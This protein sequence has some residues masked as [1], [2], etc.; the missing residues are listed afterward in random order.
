MYELAPLITDLAIILGI[1]GV[2]ALIC[3]RIN[4]PVILGYLL[5]GLLLGPHTPPYPFVEDM[6]NI[7]TLSELGVIF[8]MFSLGLEF[9][10]HKLKRVGFTATITAFLEVAG[11]VILG[12]I[13]GLILG[14]SFL[15]SLFL[16]GALSISSTTIIIKALDELKLK[17]REFAQVIFGILVVEDLIAIIVLVS[18][19]LTVITESFFSTELAFSIFRLVVVVGTWFL[20]G[21]FLIPSFF[22]RYSKYMN[23][24]TL[25]LISVGLCLFLVCIASYFHYSVA[26]GAFI[27]GSILAETSL[28]H[29]IE[30]LIAPIKDIF[31]AVFFVS[32]G[33]L[34]DP[35]VIFDQWKLVLLLCFLTILGKFLF[36]ALGA[37]LSGQSVATSTRVGLGMAQIGEFSFIIIGT[38]LTLNAISPEIYPIIVA[39]SVVTT[40]ATP[41]FLKFSD[42]ISSAMIHNIPSPLKHFINGYTKSVQRILNNPR[43]KPLYSKTALRLLITGIIAAAIFLMI[44]YIMRGA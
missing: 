6:P 37:F 35:L 9:S 5:A 27:M 36:T 40:F 34:I 18:L 14:W 21:Y 3:R 15:D 42:N 20:L 41:Y 23:N 29:R 31:A 10:F 26:L 30:P 22:K 17:G 43:Y 4:Q 39:V 32:V 12:I 19:T 44:E 8:L 11:M 38:G 13:V 16:G 24:E 33:M 7:K 2:V 1:S 28:I 25:M